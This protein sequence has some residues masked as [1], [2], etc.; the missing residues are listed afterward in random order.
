MRTTNNIH[1]TMLYEVEAVSGFNDGTL[2]DMI[3]RN[4]RGD[5]GEI[6]LPWPVHRKTQ[7]IPGWFLKRMAQSGFDPEEVTPHGVPPSTR[8]VEKGSEKAPKIPSA[9]R[10][11]KGLKD[12]ITTGVDKDQDGK[13]LTEK[14][15]KKAI[16]AELEALG[17]TT[18]SVNPLKY[19]RRKL[20]EEKAELQLEA[21]EQKQND[22]DDLAA[23]Q[24]PEYGDQKAK[25]ELE[26]IEGVGNLQDDND[27]K[28]E[29][30]SDG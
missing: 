21:D 20:E 12:E 5:I 30:E 11:A 28:G 9:E 27:A 23:S 3:N 22:L 10:P 13:D 6:L 7:I 2:K 26:E 8:E 1:N 14:E 24:R 17:V 19:L 18:Y 16:R 15:E 25:A 29:K 4:E